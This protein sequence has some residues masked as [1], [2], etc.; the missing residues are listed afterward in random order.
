VERSVTAGGF[1]G[2][3]GLNAETGQRRTSP[4]LGAWFALDVPGPLAV[5]AQVSWFP[6]NEAIEFEAQGGRTVKLLGGVRGTVV[7]SP[8]VRI[9]ALMRAGIIRFS[10][11]EVGPADGRTFIAS[12]SHA[13]LD[14][15]IGA[16]L[17]P[18]K[19][20]SPRVELVRALYDVPGASFRPSI[21]DSVILTRNGK[22]AETYQFTA[23]LTY[24]TS[25]RPHARSPHAADRRLVAGPLFAY[26]GAA[27]IGD[28]S[29][30]HRSGI[31]AFA[32]YRL[33]R[34]VHADASGTLF[35]GRPRVQTPWDGGS[36]LHLLGGVK[37]GATTRGIG[38]F[39]KV[40]VGTSSHA[41]AL[42]GR[43]SS[44]RRIE[45]GR[46]YLPAL[47]LGGI[48]E[49]ATGARLLLRF[50]ASELIT[51]YRSRTILLDG[52]PVPQPDLPTLSSMQ[53][54]VGA[55]WRFH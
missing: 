48:V 11:T 29:P 18:Q 6:R 20:W 47:D 25:S 28:L 40:R 30:L 55:G 26:S 54:A 33:T 42:L 16:D 5:E 49:T 53:F 21:D 41:A 13:A 39:G 14:V 1:V 44:P 2:G 27:T 51:F 34:Y 3:L 50:E 24:K 31:G 43:Q 52:V 38:V 15:G 37:L 9:D 8:A 19:R 10:S 23:G 45:A 35:P 22:I 12:R 46:A 17:W 36:N 32:S 7:D 4:G